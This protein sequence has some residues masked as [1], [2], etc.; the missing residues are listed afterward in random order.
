MKR[1][2]FIQTSALAAAG[3]A[4]MPAWADAGQF[5]MGLQLYTLRDLINKDPKGVVKMAFD[6]G[7]REFEAFGYGDG[8]LFGMP[9]REF[10]DYVKSLGGRIT[11]GHYMLGKSERMKAIKGTLTNDW[12]RAVA[13]AKAVGQEYMVLA[14]LMPDERTSMDDYKFVC[15]KLNAASEVCKNYGV[16]L[17]YHNHDFE[18][19]DFNGVKPLDMMLSQLDPAKVSFELDL[20]WTIFANQKPEDY[21][22][23]YPGRFPQWHVK[24]MDKAD[25]KKNA[26]IG[27][28]SIDFKSIFQ[29]AAHAGLKHYYAEHDTYPT[30]STDAVTAAVSYLKQL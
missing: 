19:V 4:A 30:N 10:S 24:D 2:T 1:R 29:H 13:D 20:Y 16:K 6:L 27:T 23:K 11:S 21:F 26:N 15:E 17:S 18:F 22:M 8:K 9:A 14:F 7:Y 5:A 28:G 25:R 3:L 12:E